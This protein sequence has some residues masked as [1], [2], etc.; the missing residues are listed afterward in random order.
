MKNNQLLKVLT[1][2]LLGLYIKIGYTVESGNQNKFVE[3]ASKIFKTKKSFE[4]S[5]SSPVKKV[6]LTKNAE[7]SSKKMT[8]KPYVPNKVQQN[9]DGFS[10]HRNRETINSNKVDQDIDSNIV[11][12]QKS[13]PDSSQNNN[14]DP[15]KVVLNFENADIQSVI[16]AIGKLSGKNFVIDPRVKG[17]VNI[18]SDQPVSKSDSYKVLETALRMQGFACVEADGVIKVLPEVDAKTYGMSTM[19]GQ[20]DTN[21]MLGDQLVTKVF[22]IAHGSATQLANALRPLIAPNN[23]ISVYTSSNAIVITDY[24]TNMARITK[25]LNQLTTNNGRP[26]E[27]LVITLKHAIAADVAQLLQSY[28][29][30]SSSGGGSSG[31]GGYNSDGP[32]ASIS[33]EPASNSI[34]ISSP[35]QE[36]IDELKA[37]VLKMDHEA[38]DSNNNLHVVYLKNADAN[39][40]ADVLRTIVSGQENP[41][42]V[43]SSSQYK[44]TNEPASIFASSGGGGGASGSGGLGGGSAPGGTS[45]ASHSSSS[46]KTTGNSSNQKDAPKVLIQAEETTNSLIIEATASIC[47]PP[48]R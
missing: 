45:A 26:I 18:V 36:K 6:D 21:K 19:S 2:G 25:V 48:A 17:T 34:I 14:I 27:P 20:V 23:T 15:N 41:D 11:T 32:P 42:L 8:L 12:N 47:V 29:G 22:V 5:I 7:S 16:K 28:Q 33:V 9:S 10:K 24:S 1:I 44:F 37:L 39:H 13:N 46:S 31:G 30:I 43:A 35:V 38:A 3:S 4:S 40:I